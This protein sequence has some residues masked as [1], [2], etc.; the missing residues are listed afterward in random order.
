M[1][2]GR[3]HTRTHVRTHKDIFQAASTSC[4]ACYASSAQAPGRPRG[5]SRTCGACA[6]PVG[7]VHKP[8]HGGGPREGGQERSA[9]AWPA[10]GVPGC[11]EG[12]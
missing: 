11:G 5:L 10:G 6:L 1:P 8:V 2:E 7:G 4:C 12:V 3:T 9:R